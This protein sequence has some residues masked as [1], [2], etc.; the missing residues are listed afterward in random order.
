MARIKV[1]V[2]GYG[3]IGKRVADAVALQ[4]DMELAG[5]ADVVAD[6]RIKLAADRGYPVFGSSDEAVPAIRA[7][8]LELA[9]TL[10][11][12]LDE[13]DVVV[14]ATPK[15]V[16]AANRDAYAAAGVKALYQGGE[17]HELTGVSF[18]AQANYAEALGR[19]AARVVSCNTTGLVRLLSALQ[20]RNLVQRAR[21]VLVRRATDPWESH[22]GGMVNTLLPETTIPSH[23]GPDAQTVLPGLDIVT[24][25][26]AGP[27]NLSHV[28]F[29]IVEAP[30]EVDR[31]EVLAA[32]RDAPRIAFVRAADGVEAPNAVIEIARDLGRP[33]ADLWEVAV[34]EDTLAV[35]GRE[36]FLTYQVHNEAIVIPENVDAIRAVTGVEPDGAKSIAAT[37]AALGVRKELY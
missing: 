18:V 4:S 5:V 17:R 1:A 29:A 24:I 35:A 32:L 31:K 19:E 16:G 26:A 15:K 36:I 34:W 3:V 8:G 22:K 25:A 28:H 7:A 6:Y 10:A 27:F 14:D 11:D 30:G 13:A 23:Q 33:R 21:A 12:L 9:G 37:D 2:N 20:A